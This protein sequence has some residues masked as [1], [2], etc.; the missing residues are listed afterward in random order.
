MSTC[1]VPPDL[2][3]TLVGRPIAIAKFGDALCAHTYI[4]YYI[5][6]IVVCRIED[7]E[8]SSLNDIKLGK[9][10]SSNDGYYIE[11]LYLSSSE[12]NGRGGGCEQNNTKY[13]CSSVRYNCKQNKTKRTV[14]GYEV[15]KRS[16]DVREKTTHS[17]DE[18]L[19]DCA[20]RIGE[21]ATFACVIVVVVLRA[22][23]AIVMMMR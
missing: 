23:C 13:Q 9:V 18:N 5:L 17:M 10:I 14:G 16:A 15:Q 8:S 1:S 7:N 3:S 21:H 11:R 6:Y 4:I 19:D 2:C 20:A 12:N 22:V